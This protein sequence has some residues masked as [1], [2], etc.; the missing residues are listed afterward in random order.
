MRRHLLIC[1]VFAGV[2]GHAQAATVSTTVELTSF[3]M[4]QFWSE[5]HAGLGI[6]ANGTEVTPADA[7]AAFASP[8]SVWAPLSGSSVTFSYGG[9]LAL[10]R[11]NSFEFLGATDQT[12]ADVGS[13]NLFKLGTVTYKNGAFNPLAFV[14]FT[15][16][17]H[18]SD[19]RFDNRTFSGAI[20]LD[21]RQS[22]LDWGAPGLPKD[23]ADYFTILN[24]SATNSSA[25]TLPIGSVRVYDYSYCPVGDA[26]A[27]DCNVGSADLYGYVGS[28]HVDHFANATGG[29]FLDA[30]TGSVPTI[31][32]P[33]TYAMLLAGLGLLGFVARRRKQN[34]A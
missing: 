3:T 4:G 27:P 1:L 33:E 12:V 20:R 24:S 2:C 19:S 6:I 31:P 16:T 13:G 29:A 26:S 25:T 32:E 18:S 22:D 28:L 15:I 9:A 14:D 5:Y 11:S 8:A 7:A 23:E 30:S 17:T 34:A 10:A 21:V